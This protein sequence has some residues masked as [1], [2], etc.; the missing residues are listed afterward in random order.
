MDRSAERPMHS[1]RR[2]DQ[3]LGDVVYLHDMSLAVIALLRLF[4]W[5]RWFGRAGMPTNAESEA[6]ASREAKSSWLSRSGP[7]K[8]A[9][10]WLASRFAPDHFAGQSVHV[11][12]A[13]PQDIDSVMAIE[14]G[15]VRSSLQAVLLSRQ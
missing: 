12:A 13:L 3:R 2:P 4:L 11:F 1:H 10:A 14:H 7:R 9:L 5:L 6:E 8:R 15:T